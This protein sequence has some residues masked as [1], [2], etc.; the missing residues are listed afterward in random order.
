MLPYAMF[1]LN[2]V[3]MRQ[4]PVGTQF[5]IRLTMPVGSF[6]TKA[7]SPVEAVLIAPVERNGETILPEGSILSGVVTRAQSVGFGIAHETAALALDFDTCTLPNGYK[8]PMSTRLIE[9]ENGRE[10]VIEDGTIRGVRTTSSISYRATGYIRTALAWEVHAQLAIWATKMLVVQVPEPEI[11][12][13]AGVEM[14]LALRD[15]AMG[16]VQ[17]DTEPAL[18]G[19]DRDELRTI[20]AGMPYRAY[21]PGSNRPSDLMN[22][23]FAGTREE[24][25]TAFKAAGWTEAS[26]RTLRSRIVGARAVAE[27]RGDLN[28]PMSRLLAGDRDPDMLWEKGLNDVSKRHHVRIWKQDGTWEGKPLWIGAATRDIDFAFLRHGGSFTHKIASN[29]DEER[30][31]IAHDFEF[32]GC[33]EAVDWWDRPG[34]PTDARNA[35]GDLMNTDGELAVIRMNGCARPKR[36][37]SADAESLKYRPNFFK[38]VIRREILSVRSDFYRTNMY[39]RAYEGTRW[40]VLAVKNRHRLQETPSDQAFEK[41]GQ[42]ADSTGFL[43]RAKNSSWLR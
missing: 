26:P 37:S 2:L 12:Y 7:G 6:A 21:Q 43:S 24:I 3:L 27:G 28:A 38:R 8:I 35:T 4:M 40:L 36:A 15:A 29:L 13:P 9:V 25:E 20:T 39:W 31:K 19:D 32:T 17:A 18:D 14:T 30:D 5:H 22:V 11:Y 34:A 16:S 42:M 10:R 1:A 23:L 33:T 41:R